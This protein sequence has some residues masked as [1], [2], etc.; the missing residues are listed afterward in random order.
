MYVC[1]CYRGRVRRGTEI[2]H[3]EC[4]G[5]T[6]AV[7]CT[8]MHVQIYTFSIPHICMYIHEHIQ[9]HCIPSKADSHQRRLMRDLVIR[10]LHL[11]QY[12]SIHCDGVAGGV[13]HEETLAFGQE[14]RWD[15]RYFSTS[16]VGVLRQ[17]CAHTQGL[18]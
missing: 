4:M 2:R 3:R 18:G 9:M 13:I 11:T 15:P 12:L 6:M 16:D 10:W 8:Y 5:L 14:T 7:L 17:S 1:V